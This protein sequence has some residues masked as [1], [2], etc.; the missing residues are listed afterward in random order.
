[1]KIKFESTI[2]E[3]VDVQL[4]LI[5]LSKTA[6]KWKWEGL[7]FVPIIFAGFYFCLPNTIA[8]KLILS[9]VS[10]LLF[11]VIYLGSYKKLTRTR[12]KKLLIENFGT[13]KP[14]PCEYEFE[15]EGL[16][17]RRMGTDLKF[18][19]CK[20]TKINET[21]KDLE[22][23]IGKTGIAVIPKRIF[24]NEQQKNEWVAFAKEKTKIS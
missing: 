1:M 8:I 9:M 7:L 14:L 2:D 3:A 16:I 11:I 10:S 17:F 24:E 22:L 6:K 13:D 15:E 5:E 12:I 20:V 18:Q 21:E 19:W 4:R 23:I